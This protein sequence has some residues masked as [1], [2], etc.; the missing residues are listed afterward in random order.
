MITENHCPSRTQGG[1]MSQPASTAA[2]ET[3]ATV[4]AKHRQPVLAELRTAAAAEGVAFFCCD[5]VEI[6]LWH[7][8]LLLAGVAFFLLSFADR[9]AR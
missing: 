7:A 5:L 2:E 9:P 3:C 1:G 8:L 4:W 6:H